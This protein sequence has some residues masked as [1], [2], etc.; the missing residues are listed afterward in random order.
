M[1]DSGVT[2]KSFSSPW[3][4]FLTATNA[5][6]NVFNVNAADWNMQSSQ[7]VIDA[8]AGATVL[9]NI[10]GSPIAITNC[11]IALVGVDQR[12]V[13]YNYADA[14]FVSTK[15]FLH[16]GSVLAP[17]AS[18]ALSGGAINGT[19]VFGGDVTTSIGFEFHNFP[20]AGQVSGGGPVNHPPIVHA[21][22]DIILP[23]N[24]SVQLSGWAGDDGQP[25]P[26]Q[27]VTLW[28]VASGSAA[29]VTFDNPAVTNT[30]A[31]FLAGGEYTLRLNG[32]DGTLT[33]HDTVSVTVVAPSNQPPF[34]TA[35]PDRVLD[36]V[37]ALTLA[38]FVSDDGKPDPST[39][40]VRWRVVVGDADVVS[41]GDSS[42]TNTSVAFG[43]IGSY[44]LRLTAADGA[45]ATYDEMS[46]LVQL[47]NA[48]PEVE[49]GADFEIVV[50]ARISLQGCVADDGQPVP[51][52][53]STQWSVVSGDAAAVEMDDSSDPMTAVRFTATGSFTLQLTAF[54]GE[55]STSD[56]LAVIVLPIPNRPPTVYAGPAQEIALYKSCKLL[57]MVEDDGLPVS[58]TVTLLWEQTGGLGTAVISDGSLAQPVVSFPV[59]GLYTFRLTASDGELSAFSDTTVTV[60]LANQPPQV[61]AGDDFEMVAGLLALLRGQVIDDGLPLNGDSWIAW[62][63]LSGPGEAAFESPDKAVSPVT[64]T[65][66][67]EYVF[68]LTASDGENT[69]PDE[70]AVRFGAATNLAPV[71]DAGSDHTL[72]FNLVRTANLV[73]NPG[74]ETAATN[75]VV[76]GWNAL[77]TAWQ[78][79]ASNSAGFA[80]AEGVRM[81]RPGVCAASELWQDVDVSL[82]A[83]TID[84]NRQLFEFST[85]Y[86]VKEQIRYDAPRITVEYRDFNGALL[87]VTDISPT[88]ISS[89]WGLLA[90]TRVAPA[91]TRAVRIRLRAENSGIDAANDV[92]FDAVALCAVELAGVILSGSVTDDGRPAGGSL[93]SEWR[94]VSGPVAA[95]IDNAS[96][97]SPAVYFSAPGVYELAL[98]ADDGEL[99]S[100]DSMTVAVVDD[101]SGLPLSVDA[102]TNQVVHLPLAMAQLQGAVGNAGTNALTFSWTEVSGHARVF[103]EN[104]DTLTPSVRFYE[105]GEYTLRLSVSDGIQI[106]YDEICVEVTFPEI[107]VPMDVV[108]V[109]DHS[110]SMYGDNIDRINNGIHAANLFAKR[111]LPHDRAAVVP[112]CSEGVVVQPLTF[113]YVA[114]TSAIP[115][116]PAACGSGTAIDKGIAVAANH[117]LAE[118]RPSAQ[119]VILLLSDGGADGSLSTTGAVIAAAQAAQASGIQIISV[120][121][122]KGTDETLMSAV[123]SSRG[124]YFFAASSEDLH[125]LYGSLSRSFCRLGPDALEVHAG[126]TVVLPNVETS[127]SLLGRVHFGFGSALFPVTAEWSMLSGPGQVVFDNP[128]SAVTDAVFSGPGFY[129]L[130]LTGRTFYGQD[131]L[132]ERSR[133]VSVFV[134]EPSFVTSPSGL[135]SLWRGEGNALDAIANRHAVEPSALRYGT[136]AVGQ[137]FVFSNGCGAVAIPP[138]SEGLNAGMSD[139]GFTVCFF[140][141]LDENS[142]AQRVFCWNNRTDGNLQFGLNKATGSYRAM[143][144]Y[145]RDAE[146]VLQT[147]TTPNYTF[148]Y[149]QRH[150]FA[151]SYDRLSGMLR[152]F[153]DGIIW[154]SV[155]NVGTNGILTDGGFGFGNR[156]D[157]TLPLNGSLDE[158]GVFDRPLRADEIWGLAQLSGSGMGAFGANAAPFVDAGADK[159]LHSTNDVLDIQG[160]V[161]DDGLPLA[162]VLRTR[163]RLLSGPGHAAFA[164]PAA[165]DTAVSFSAPGVYI[166]ELSADDG[167]AGARD[168]ARVTV[169]CAADFCL[170]PAGLRAHWPAEGTGREVVSGFDASPV[171]AVCYTQSVVGTGFAHNAT[172]MMLARTGGGLD[173]GASTNGFTVEFWARID[174]Y[175]GEQVIAGWYDAGGAQFAVVKLSSNYGY[176][177]IYARDAQGTLR[178]HNTSDSLYAVGAW[179]H[180]AFAYEPS[181]G[182]LRI[183]RDGVFFQTLALSAGGFPTPGD[184]CIGG[185]TGNANLMLSA[186]TDEVSVYDRCLRPDEIWT[187]CAAPRGKAVMEDNH[188]PTVFAG[189]D[190]AVMSAANGITLEGSAADDH[191]PE[192]RLE[193]QWRQ[194]TGDSPVAFDDPADPQT[195]ATFGTPGIYTLELSANDGLVVSRDTVRIEVS[196]TNQLAPPAGLCAHWPAEGTGREVVS[197]Y[198]ASPVGAVC[199]TQ[200][201]VGAGFAHN[202]TGMMLARTGGGLDVGSSTNGFTVEFWARIDSYSGEQ[203][204]AGWYNAGGAQFAVVKLSSNY[205]Y[206]R[207]YARDAQG[208]LQYHTTSY[209]LY[210]VGAWHHFAFAYE[211]SNGSLR[212]Y[213]DGVFFQTLALS[214]GGFPTPGDFCIGG[215]TGNANLVL[216]G[217]TDEVS[218]YDRALSAAE[219]QS[220]YAAGKSVIPANQPPDVFAGYD[221]TLL[222]TLACRLS[223]MVSDDGCPTNA[224]LTSEWTQL[225]GPGAAQI[226]DPSALSSEVA[227]PDYGTY[228]FRLTV[229]DGEFTRTSDV[230]VTLAT[231]VPA[232]IPPSADAGQPAEI[233]LPAQLSLTGSASDPDN[234]PSPLATLWSLV[235]GPADV[236][237]GDPASLVTAAT[238][239]HP[240]N[241]V[242]RLSANDGA[243][244]VHSHV[245]VLVHPYVANAAPAAHAGDDFTAARWTTVTLA[246]SASDDGVPSPLTYVWSLVSGP[247]AVPFSD[248][249]APVTRAQFTQPGSYVLKLTAF[250][251]EKQG[252][253]TVTVTVYTSANQP[254]AADAGGPLAAVIGAPV[255]LLPAVTDDGLPDGW[256][257]YFWLYDAGSGGCVLSRDNQSGLVSATFSKVGEHALLLTASDGEHTVTDTLTVNVTAPG[258]DG[259]SIAIVAPEPG[260]QAPAGGAL[261]IMTDA[262]DPQGSL[263]EVAFYAN[264]QYLGTRTNAPWGLTWQNLPAGTQTLHA[265]AMNEIGQQTASAPV[266]IRLQPVPPGISL[267]LPE[268]GSTLSVGT[269]FIMQAAPVGGAAVESVEFLVNG[270]SAAACAAPPYVSVYQFAAAGTFQLKARALLASGGTL[271]SDPVTVHAVEPD[272]EPV[273]LTLYTP[274]H[275]STVTAPTDIAGTL[276][277]GDVAT[278]TLQLRSRATGQETEADWQTLATGA[279]PVGVPGVPAVLG[280]IDPTLLRN[281]AYELRVIA[282]DLFGAT[283]VFDGHSIVLDGGMKVGPFQ[284]SFEDLNMPLVGIPVQLLRSYDSRG[285]SAADFGPDWELGFRSVQVQTSD[286]VGEGW[287][288]YVIRTVMGIPFY[289]IRPVRRHV[290]SVLVGDEV[291]QFEA[292]SPTE[293]GIFPPENASV[294]FRPINGSVGTLS[295]SEA[296][297]GNF[298]LSRSDDGVTLVDFVAIGALDPEDWVYR[299]ADGTR[300]D[301]RR[302]FGLRKLTDRNANSL[303]FTEDGITH[304]SGESVA[305]TRDA[306]GRITAITAPGGVTLGYAYD[307]HG[308][309]ASFV[310]R[311]GETNRFEYVPHPAAPGRR[312]LQTIVDPL[313]NR[314]LAA[315]YD[316]D[317]RLVSQTDAAGN[318][319]TFANDIPNRRQT[320]TDRLGNATVHEYDMRGNIVRTVDALGNV[321]LRGY[322]ENDNEVSVTDPLG[323]VTT[324]TFDAKRNKLTETDPLGH[325]TSYTY[326]DAGNQLSSVDPL[327]RVTLNTYNEAGSPLTTT[328][329]MGNTSGFGYDGAGNLNE[330][331]DALGRT[332]MSMGYNAAG[333]LTQLTDAAGVSRSFTYDVLGNQT[334]MSSV[335]VNPENP[336]DTREVST[337]TQYDSSGRATNTVDASGNG[338]WTRYNAAGKPLARADKLG[339]VTEFVYDALGNAIQT[340]L[341]TGLTSE[342]VYDA[343]GR[344]VLSVVPHASGAPAN[345]TRTVYDALG[346]VVRTEALSGVVIAISPQQTDNGVEFFSQVTSPGT[347]ISAE[348]SVYDAA[349]RVIEKIEPTGASTRYA[350]DAAGRNTAIADDNDNLTEFEYDAAGQRVLTRDALGRESRFVFDPL[351]RQISTVFSDGTFA[352]NV[353]DTAGNRIAEIDPAGKVR[354]FGYDAQGRLTG[355]TMPEVPDPFN[356]NRL[357]SPQYGYGYSA[358][359]TLLSIIDPLSRETTFGYDHL[360]RQTRR[361]LPL[362]QSEHMEYDSFGRLFRKTDFKGQITEF[363]YN[364]N[365]QVSSKRLYAAGA[366]EPDQ[367]VDYAYDVFGRLVSVCGPA[368]PDATEYPSTTFSY[369]SDNRIVGTQTPE[370][371]LHYGYDPATGRRTQAYEILRNPGDASYSTNWVSY[372]YDN[373]NRLVHEVMQVPGVGTGYEAEYTYDLAGNRVSR[374]V[375]VAGQI[376]TTSYAYDA[377]DRLL[378]EESAVEL[379]ALAV[380]PSGALLAGPGGS[381]LLGSKSALGQLGAQ[382]A[383]LGCRPLP[384]VWSRVGFYAIPAFLLAAFL[385]PIL[386]GAPGLR[387][388]KVR[389]M[390]RLLTCYR[391]PLIMRGTASLLAATTLVMGLPFDA[392]AQES[393]LYSR[394]ETA[395]W[396]RA[397][398]VTQY[399]YDDNGSLVSK[400]V[401]GGGAPVVETYSYDLQNRL[402][403]HV[404]T[405]SDGADVTVTSTAYRYNLEGI[406]VGKATTV[407]VNGVAYPDLSETV[408]YLIDSANPTGYAQVIEERDG[409]GTVLKSYAIGDDVLSQSVPSS[410]SLQAS[411]FLYD[412]HGSTRQLTDA[413]GAVTAQYTYDAYGVMLGQTAGAQARQ[414]TSL[415][416]SGERFDPALQQYYLRARH[417]NQAN[418]QF[419]SLDPYSG[420]PHDPQSLHKYAYC[421]ADPVNGIDPSGEMTIGSLNMATLIQGTLLTLRIAG[422]VAVVT[423]ARITMF[424]C[425]KYIW[426]DFSGANRSDIQIRDSASAHRSATPHDCESIISKAVEVVQKAF[427]EFGVVVSRN[428]SDMHGD[429]KEIDFAHSFLSCI[430]GNGLMYPGSD[431][432]YVF[433]DNIAKNNYEF[434]VGQWGRFLG[435]VASHELG[436]GYGLWH[437][438]NPSSI[439]YDLGSDGEINGAWTALH[440]FWLGLQLKGKC[441]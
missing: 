74:G 293:Q 239:S 195:H 180:F 35:G 182:S 441:P 382:T 308:Y 55:L 336:T 273:M 60:T 329:Q 133:T 264:G 383:M 243:A 108:L 23:V 416:Y 427:S 200:S 369:D 184:F 395:N 366:T 118:G 236:A 84:D 78:T 209:S 412:G 197:G 283:T 306:A 38:G 49:A 394:L 267:L 97:L 318:A 436:H 281:G 116:A 17:F 251:G 119:W 440:R 69:V 12:S 428:R 268:D 279:A 423:L 294:A 285:T 317:G 15:S 9:V 348:R 96:S 346:R 151:L 14:A 364:G 205:G 425:E 191:L 217:A 54:D 114:V 175:S 111:L 408:N 70:V 238:F 142:T 438:D 6:L 248:P 127:A 81:L 158:V 374:R 169:A 105:L 208:T 193:V 173:V 276:T 65:A 86:R 345:A 349:G 389:G 402:A 187:I 185:R 392:L 153:R 365:G 253:D 46:V 290:V 257:S 82:F 62:T 154:H 216:S 77:G 159:A 136:G 307:E 109:I 102:G 282:A 194:L 161:S 39:L 224:T 129:P 22:T 155:S 19:A 192:A 260:A 156:P 245:A 219:I 83:D 246:G 252:T 399:A 67:G 413:S 298:C 59:A 31:A 32:S 37:G 373:L 351:G 170:P 186:A 249:C 376:L 404:R 100:E 286:P 403:G 370:G 61:N 355:V 322:D 47:P 147:F 390:D 314:A 421:H 13:L 112:F 130:E 157:G 123:A 221:R 406:Q 328:D 378:R 278:Y 255:E 137:C 424:G 229:S 274:L 417:Y 91:G 56:T 226:L 339:N 189:P 87:A 297:A 265:V 201:V 302:V 430:G 291:Q 232:N 29:H 435:N 284:L 138:F 327:G 218:V 371:T 261:T 214:A 98:R 85:H 396:G 326:D 338:A 354:Q 215:R 319:V 196:C 343:E 33:A 231:S 385:L 171:G 95:I 210:T 275:G 325:T 227:F 101:G 211:P 419:T 397:G 10:H 176:F 139:S 163:W 76:P 122:C 134:D 58:G 420:N 332:T 324:R 337:L 181:N 362:G 401:T 387:R 24:G 372:T 437:D 106:A 131:L 220:G 198:H 89:S 126:P 73:V 168:T 75:G 20:F 179:H 190:R 300:L 144:I 90:D 323:N 233:T 135:I 8:P 315:G 330:M 51:S 5:A 72:D 247:A 120:G 150:H 202:A 174:S 407:T 228:R 299:T 360:N 43:E 188:A 124:D 128:A 36:A 203:V 88:P 414:A 164:D 115:Q 48:A 331:R 244:T 280:R 433:M 11:S 162:S 432:G 363:L 40:N 178:Y 350:F 266:V 177:R 405:E 341:P 183:Y 303:T 316:D 18:A 167:V 309:L 400:S 415:L 146:G 313:G 21:G 93:T 344:A 296:D 358:Y 125:A 375:W 234:G 117:L 347:V 145:L 28:E 429:F 320:V 160:F 212:I 25:V 270:S 64:V 310:N 301:I 342:T 410:L 92:F 386:T 359:G 305:F 288:D 439:M 258:R 241:Y 148:N 1:P 94:M 312:L 165:P 335:W 166:L 63:L 66:E 368:H 44:V 380:S 68:R 16:P 213:R 79:V 381:Q 235:T 99:G 311:A 409:G 4:R 295:L 263:T 256:I 237:F 321:T 340:R 45:A 431:L 27:L 141:R 422:A 388:R 333:R 250:D 50:G 225:S 289:G 206:F 34:V 287:E 356:Q 334:G 143:Q 384:S 230:S 240:G 80:A 132:Y 272:T 41:F 411:Y 426:L 254:P 377:N 367:T 110:G 259:P 304:S 292:Y 199:Y 393:D 277:G 391:L 140:L 222:D 242:L 57:G 149:E 26:P 262:S 172:G 42:L 379:A 7:T 152:L 3:Q 204:I 269:P 53:L 352:S 207:I 418:G 30:T 104:A 121:L 2:A 103:I 357:V 71:V 223:G 361:T 353:F 52:M 271:L 398:S 107:L 113:D 434:T